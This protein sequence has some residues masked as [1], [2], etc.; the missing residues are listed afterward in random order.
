VGS[1]SSTLFEQRGPEG[2]SSR[3]GAFSCRAARSAERRAV[4]VG[5]RGI[6]G[7]AR[8]ASTN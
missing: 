8:G 2:P 1:R 6:D 4:G 3:R 7:S 5:P